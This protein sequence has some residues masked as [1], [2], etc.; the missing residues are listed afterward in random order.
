MAW[1]PPQNCTKPDAVPDDPFRELRRNLSPEKWEALLAVD[2]K[3][4]TETEKTW[5]EE[6]RAW[7]TDMRDGK[8]H[9]RCE[10]IFLYAEEEWLQKENV[11]TFA[12]VLFV[13]A[14]AWYEV[15]QQP[16][17]LHYVVEFGDSVQ[18]SA[19]WENKEHS[20]TAQVT[21]KNWNSPGK[22]G[23]HGMRVRIWSQMFYGKQPFY[24]STK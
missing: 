17:G 14:H 10:R 21:V 5:L 3:D 18:C 13:I 19:T 12:R 1:Q 7:L 4:L 24:M 20:F 22:D 6:M 11:T 15:M 9:R 16:L 23:M 8:A 2:E